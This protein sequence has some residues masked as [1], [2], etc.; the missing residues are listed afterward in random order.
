[1][2][3]PFTATLHT[4]GGLKIEKEAIGDKPCFLISNQ[5]AADQL[6]QVAQQLPMPEWQVAVELVT[7]LVVQPD[8]PRLYAVCDRLHLAFVEGSA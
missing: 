3:R 6:L 1:K 8:V 5:K 2:G 4:V 7:Q